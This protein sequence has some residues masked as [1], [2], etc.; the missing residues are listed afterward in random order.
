MLC[1]FVQFENAVLPID[2]TLLGIVTYCK[3]E[4]STK[5]L[6][7]IDSI[8]LGKATVMRARQPSNTP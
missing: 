2:V 4:Q 5:V 8:P 6:T 7:G 3:L 1:S